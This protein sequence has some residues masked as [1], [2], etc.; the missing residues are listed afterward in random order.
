MERGATLVV[1]GQVTGVA[2]HADGDRPE[3]RFVRLQ[4]RKGEVRILAQ[5]TA[6]DAADLKKQCGHRAPLAITIDTPRTLH[7]VVPRTGP[8]DELMRQVGGKATV[9]A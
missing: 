6:N 1:S 2:V 7:R 5:G 3:L 9:R 4:R 8:L